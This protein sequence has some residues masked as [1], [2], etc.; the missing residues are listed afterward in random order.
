[1]QGTFE[2]QILTNPVSDSKMSKLSLQW[3]AKKSTSHIWTTRDRHQSENDQVNARQSQFFANPSETEV[4]QLKSNQIK[5][6]YCDA[7]FPWGYLVQRFSDSFSCSWF[8]VE[9]DDFREREL[10]MRPEVEKQGR[11]TAVLLLIFVNEGHCHAKTNK[12]VEL[13][14]AKVPKIHPT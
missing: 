8:A 1:M 4:D 7:F 12:V 11:N 13:G 14:S 2:F 6:V 10:L 3:W 5:Y 9:T